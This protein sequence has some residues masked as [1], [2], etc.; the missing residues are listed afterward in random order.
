VSREDR[1]SNFS[2]PQASSEDSH[3]PRRHTMPLKRV[4]QKARK[5]MRRG[6]SASSAAGEFVREEMHHIREGK[7][8]AKN[9][10]QAIAIGLSEAR[11]AGIPIPDKRGGSSR[12]TRSSKGSSKKRSASRKR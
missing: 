2:A 8:G 5:D 7:H 4:T 6:K 11:R 10:R 9:A 12:A 3:S 1:F